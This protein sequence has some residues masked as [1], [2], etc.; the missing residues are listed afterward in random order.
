MLRVEDIVT[1]QSIAIAASSDAS[2]AIPFLGLEFFP[3]AK[4]SGIDLRWIKTHKNASPI[5]APSNYDALPVLRGRDGIQIQETEMPFFRESMKV[6]ER[7]MIDIGRAVDA[8]DPYIAS[9][10]QGIYDDT[11]NLVRSAEVVPEVMRMQLLAAAGGHPSI[12]ISANNQTYAYNYDPDGSYATNNYKSLTGQKMWNDV[13]NSTP[14]D[15]LF[16]AKKTLAANGYN[17]RYVVMTTKTFGYVRNNAQVKALLLS[18]NALFASDDAV[19]RIIRDTTGLEV[20]IYDK[21]YTDIAT[22][23]SVNFYPDDQVTLIPDEQLGKTWFGTTPV[24]RSLGQVTNA[25]TAIYGTGIAVTTEPKV[26]S[27]VYSFTT[28]ASEIVL[29]SYEKMDATYVI[30]VVN[31]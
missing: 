14:I 1:P 12:A 24:E 11:N 26:D 16:N 25:Q 15:D 9:A 18:V 17:A 3:E 22:G 7:D 27:G 29:P 23:N 19:K 21:T 13:T 20:V 28:T 30:K 31:P 5:L 4:K 10:L 2:N 8:T 6:T